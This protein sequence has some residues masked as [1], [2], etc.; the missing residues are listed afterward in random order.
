MSASWSEAG[1]A[2]HR[3]TRK[4]FAFWVKLPAGR[5]TAVVGE[6]RS[7]KEDE[8]QGREEGQGRQIRE[9]QSDQGLKMRG[10]WSLDGNSIIFI[11]LYICQN[12][13][14]ASFLNHIF[15]QISC[16]RICTNYRFLSI[17]AA[18]D[19]LTPIYMKLSQLEVQNRWMFPLSSLK[20][21]LRAVHQ[22]IYL[23]KL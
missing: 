5:G 16:C 15:D 18:W 21:C 9:G 3:P 1:P 23:S 10:K 6:G 12:N 7:Q 14:S 2:I 20:D 4:A 22:N 17:M 8:K 11:H 19:I 13:I